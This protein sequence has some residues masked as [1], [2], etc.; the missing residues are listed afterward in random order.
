MLVALLLSVLC[1]Y[2]TSWLILHPDLATALLQNPMPGIPQPADVIVVL[3]GDD[4]RASYATSLIE[5]GLAPRMLSTLVDPACIHA[6][7]SSGACSTGVRN[8]VDEAL[9]MRRILDRERVE[10]VMVVTSRTHAV[11]AAAIFSVVFLGSGIDLNVVT[12]PNVSYRETQAIRELL[13]FF[14]SLGCA[15]LGRVSP[16]LYEWIMQYSPGYSS[17]PL[18]LPAHS[19]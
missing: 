15:V 6:G 11:R 3:A 18:Q 17:L 1:L 7:Q 16:E 2:G 9:M 14:P 13:S 8:T 19:S 4:E 5:K 10:R 12:T